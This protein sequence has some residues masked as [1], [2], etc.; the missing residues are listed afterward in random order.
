[1]LKQ[2]MFNGLP[3]NRHHSWLTDSDCT[4]TGTESLCVFICL[5]TLQLQK[6]KLQLQE[7]S[8]TTLASILATA[9][10]VVPT[11]FLSSLLLVG[12]GDDVVLKLEDWSTQ[13]KKISQ[14]IG[15]GNCLYN[16]ICLY[17]LDWNGL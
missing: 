6:Q 3:P 7:K 10:P 8:T 9:A 11:K 16:F 5:Q 15:S 1:M 14:F 2:N 13:T 12:I 4:A 17:F